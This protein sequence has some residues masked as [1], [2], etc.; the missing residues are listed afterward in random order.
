MKKHQITALLLGAVLVPMT[1][2]LALN[3]E[4]DVDSSVNVDVG[5]GATSSNTGASGDAN[6]EA[7]ASSEVVLGVPGNVEVIVVTRADVEGSGAISA[8]ASPASVSS[9]TDLSGFV[10]AQI[11]SDENLSK[12]ESSKSRVSV[13]YPQKARLFGLIPITVDATATI[14]ADGT[15]DVKYPWY[16]FLMVTNETVLESEIESR[17]TSL[18]PAGVRAVAD[19]ELELTANAQAELIDEVRAVMESQLAID[20]SGTVEL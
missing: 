14:L 9:E 2:A 13:T 6:A 5:L 7:A 12:V 11:A 15:V 10:A 1:F 18:N 19:A 16:A 3:L 17:V 4:A 20:A 8:S